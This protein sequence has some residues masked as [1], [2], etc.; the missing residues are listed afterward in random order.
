M[1]FKASLCKSKFSMPLKQTD[2]I[3]FKLSFTSALSLLIIKNLANS[4]SKCI[5]YC[6]N[7]LLT[8]DWSM[9]SFLLKLFKATASG[10]F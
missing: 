9:I 10:K 1:S 7:N 5:L 6:L 4:S 8:F 2:N 3:A